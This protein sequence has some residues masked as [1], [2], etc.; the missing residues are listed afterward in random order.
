MTFAEDQNLTSADVIITPKSAF[1]VVKHY[2]V[3]EGFDETGVD[4]YLENKQGFGVR[5][6]NGVTFR[7]ENPT[8]ESIRR[9]EGDYTSRIIALQRGTTLLGR[10]YDLSKFNCEHYANH[11]QYNSP[12]STQV[13]NFHE[14]LGKGLIAAG[15]TTLVFGL[16][17]LLNE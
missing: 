14:A 16:I 6:I 9:F 11:V 10:P 7:A 5:R 3:F 15:V 8:F 4:Y 2:I 13:N 17:R 12:V 1:N